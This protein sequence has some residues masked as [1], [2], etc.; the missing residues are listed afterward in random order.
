M[1]KIIRIAILLVI[2]YFL[3]KLC[4]SQVGSIIPTGTNTETGSGTGS[5]GGWLGQRNSGNAGNSE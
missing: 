4:T 2:A 3:V 1:K 5:G